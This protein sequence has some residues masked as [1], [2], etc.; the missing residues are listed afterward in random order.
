MG[1]LNDKVAIITGGAGGIGVATAR[2]FLQEGAKVFLVDLDE[3]T[4]QDVARALESN[5]VAYAAADVSNPADVQRYVNS[6]IE[7]FGGIDV[8]FDN[9]GTEGTLAPLTELSVED[10][11]RVLNVN[12]RGAWLAIKYAAPNMLQRGGGSIIVTSSVAG[13]IGSPGLGAYVTSKHG[14]IGLMKC[15]AQELGPQ[16]IRVNTI[17]PGPVDNRMMR[18]IESQAAPDAPEAVKAGFE[19]Q[20]PLGRYA[21]NDDVAHMAVFLASDDSAY[22]NGSTYVVDGGFLSK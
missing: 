11:D 18:S 15:A 9:A 10:F 20:I 17:N 19:G 5:N 6:C 21:T 13:F 7:T 22:C 12:C 8:L 4:L 1:K 2:K 14:V 3:D 16:G